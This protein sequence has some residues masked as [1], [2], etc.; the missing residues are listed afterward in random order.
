[1]DQVYT[2]TNKPGILIRLKMCRRLLASLVSICSRKLLKWET[3][4]PDKF[5]KL[6]E[7]GNHY[8]EQWQ[9]KLVQVASKANQQ[10]II[11]P[12]ILEELSVSSSEGDS[13]RPSQISSRNNLK[14]ERRNSQRQAILL[15]I[16]KTDQSELKRNNTSLQNLEAVT[17]NAGEDHLAEDIDSN[18]RLFHRKIFTKLF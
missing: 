16:L 10:Q 5:L 1:M 11:A 14:S 8:L 13:R 18:N 15:Q 17:S 3:Q 12:S 7:T 6:L 4:K 9:Q 2:H